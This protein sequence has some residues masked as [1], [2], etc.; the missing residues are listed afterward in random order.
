MPLPENSINHIY[1]FACFCRD[2]QKRQFN[3]ELIEG[4]LRGNILNE[5]DVDRLIFSIKHNFPNYDWVK[6]SL[7]KKLSKRSYETFRWIYEDW[8]IMKN[9][10]NINMR[11]KINDFGCDPDRFIRDFNK[12]VRTLVNKPEFV[13]MD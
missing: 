9:M 6:N 7:F 2:C 8:M 5:Y 3:E 1:G 13:L 10:K 11:S 4:I 12:I